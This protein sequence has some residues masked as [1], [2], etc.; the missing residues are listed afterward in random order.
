MRLGSRLQGLGAHDIKS[1]STLLGIIS[2]LNTNRVGDYKI[3]LVMGSLLQILNEWEIQLL[4]LVSFILQVFLFF[5]GN[6]RRHSTDM[7]LRG[8]IWLAYLGAD[9]VAI[10]ALGFLSRHED[11]TTKNIALGE[12][13]P[14][15]FLWS[16]FLLIHLG[17][18]DT[19]TAFAL[20]DN[21]L[22][23]RHLLNLV[24]QVSLALYV[25]WKSTSWPHNVQ[26]LV[27]GIFLFIAGIIKY[28]ERTISLMYGNLNNSKKSKLKSEP[29]PPNMYEDAGY[30]GI[31]S[32]ALNCAPAVR[33]L[34]AR[35]MVFEM[36]AAHLDTLRNINDV[37]YKAKVVDVELGIMYNDL[38]TKAA[39]LRT[40][41][42]IVTRCIS[43]VSIVVALVGFAV[44]NKKVYSEIDIAITYTLFIG[45]FLLEVC[46]MITMFIASPWTWAWL[47]ARGY[48]RLARISW[49]AF[50]SNIIGWPITKPLWSNPV[51]LAQRLIS[52]IR[53][54]ARAV[55][56]ADQLVKLPFWVSKMVDTKY[57][58]VD[59]KIKEAIVEQIVAFHNDPFTNPARHYQ[60][61]VPFLKRLYESEYYDFTRLISELHIFTE[62]YISEALAPSNG[63][64][65]SSE[66]I[67]LADACRKLSNY[68]LYLVAAHPAAGS[69]LQVTGGSPD[70]TLDKMQHLISCEESSSKEANL[71]AASDT[72]NRVY[73]APSAKLS[74]TQQRVEIL[75]DLRAVWVRILMYAA[76]RSRPEV[77]AA[78]LARGG[79]LLTF[80][81]ILMAHYHMGNSTSRPFEFTQPSARFTAGGMIRSTSPFYAFDLA[82]THGYL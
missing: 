59:D 79:E 30:K 12:T 9:V 38:Y 68:M 76:G 66:A 1:Q 78:L 27:P 61:L 19:I 48:R 72:L 70:I 5:T 62:V 50:S 45:C 75:K 11:A 64:R 74:S 39:L 58:A 41:S 51:T 13:H 73:E 8:T 36:S 44:S 26:V 42:G 43:Q 47:E 40:R 67:A 33:A 20:E 25:F 34:L 71:R 69:I 31:V 60:H 17:G 32:L 77:H 53:K 16:P 65:I 81:W 80:V 49:S 46:A 23:L 37:Q 4:V 7:L 3:Q 15:A 82:T 28:G 55:G 2:R 35:H 10:Y 22:W 54:K 56:T 57:E 63:P 29:K 21:S 24:V 6:V 18:Q 52:I 14:L